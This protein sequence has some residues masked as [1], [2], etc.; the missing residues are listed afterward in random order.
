MLYGVGANDP[1]T[2][3]VVVAVL[4]VVAGLACAVPAWRTTKDDPMEALRYR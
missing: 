1:L 2:I 3:A 4:S